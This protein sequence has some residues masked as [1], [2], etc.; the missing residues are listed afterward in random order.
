M[1]KTRITSGK[2]ASSNDK[3]KTSTSPYNTI[4]QSI[5][6]SMSMRK[7]RITS[8]KSASSNDKD[9]ASTSPY[10]TIMQRSRKP[11]RFGYQVLVM[12]V[13]IMLVGYSG[14]TLK[15]EWQRMIMAEEAIENLRNHVDTVTA[16][17]NGD[18]SLND[19]IKT[20]A[21][22][23]GQTKQRHESSNASIH[24]H[25]PP[26]DGVTPGCKDHTQFCTGMCAIVADFLRQRRKNVLSNPKSWS[27]Y[28]Q[29]VSDYYRCVNAK[30]VVEVGVAFGAQTA[31][32]LKN[33]EFIDE[34]HVVDPFLAGYDPEDPM[35]N[36]FMKAAPDATPDEI[37]KAWFESMDKDLGI[38]GLYN[39]ET[40]M[41]PG[42]CKLRMHRLKSVDA[43][44]LFGDLSVDAVFIDG[45]HTYEGVV[46]DIKAWKS[47]IK[48]GGSLIFNDYN[49]KA[50]FP[51]IYQAVNEFATGQRIEVKMIDATNALV[52]GK[53]TCAKG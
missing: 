10:N 6:D 24:A 1:R 11:M 35:A 18:T 27:W 45:L 16:V 26:P 39:G 32:H 28:Y 37:S 29:G 17:S 12:L 7:T 48:V 46:D 15:K 19:G 5:Q 4:T 8:G 42:G 20:N 13:A 41:Q 52:G 47:K 2:S 30:V 21:N 43:A 40:K 14:A 53:E 44:S 9:K 31:F 49:A 50:K 25:V 23:V 33:S 51:G 36:E 22:V 38:D 34:Y 3:E